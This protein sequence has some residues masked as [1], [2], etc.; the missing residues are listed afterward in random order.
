MATKVRALVE[1]GA[2]LE[3]VPPTILPRAGTESGG[4][5]RPVDEASDRSTPIEMDGQSFAAAIARVE[6]RQQQQGDAI[7]ELARAA[8]EDRVEG[9]KQN[10]E[11]NGK[12]GALV[13][14]A[15]KSDEREDK[16][17]ERAAEDRKLTRASRKEIIL[18]AIAAVATLAGAY[19]ISRSG[20][21][22]APSQIQMTAPAMPVPQSTPIAPGVR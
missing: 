20:S 19:A 3:H 11:V 8:G 10:A 12:L 16:R 18:A 17:E 13:D 2:E 7:I 15:K 6:Y 1:R 14:L 5:P 21:S 22:P 4:V 9:A